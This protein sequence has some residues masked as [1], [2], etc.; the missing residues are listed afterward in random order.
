[1][2]RTEVAVTTLDGTVAGVTPPAEVACDLVNGNVLSSLH[3]HMWLEVTNTH[4]T[5]AYT[6][7]FVT[8]STVAGRAISDD[9]VSVP[10]LGKRRFGPFDRDAYGAALQIDFQAAATFTLRGYQTVP[11]Y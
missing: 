5:I 7:T 1:M 2:P 8:P 11:G 10:A 3:D 6:I 9:I 4:A